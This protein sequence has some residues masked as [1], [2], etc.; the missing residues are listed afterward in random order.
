MIPYGK[1]S[2]DESDI[3][4]V[5]EV[6]RSDFLTCGPK[7]DEFEE[8]FA[9]M[10]GAKYAVSCANGTAALHLAMLAAKIGA[11]DRV[12]TTPI[13]FLASANCAVY[14]GAK[15][16]FADVDPVSSCLCP[17]SLAERWR[18]GTKAVVAVDFAGQPADMQAI[19]TVARERG[20]LVIEDACHAVGGKF[21]YQGVEHTVGGHEW[22]DMTVF[23]FHP[24][25]TLTTGEGGMVVTNNSELAERLRLLRCHGMVKDQQ[26][27]VS[28]GQS[29]TAIAEEQVGQLYEMQ[30]PGFNYRLS[31]IHAALGISQL[32]RLSS[33][34]TRRQEIVNQYNDAFSSLEGVEI[35]RL[36]SWLENE[37][38]DCHRLSWHLYVLRFDWA[39][40]GISR[41]ELIKRL[42]AAGVGTQV[43]YL[44]VYLQP[45]YATYFPSNGL[46]NADAVSKAA[47]SLPLYPS[48]T[49]ADVDKV[50][51]ILIDELVATGSV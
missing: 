39:G 42:R 29:G 3:A 13:T 41:P 33:F 37:G 2:I 23:S 47:L 12:V 34:V 43:H 35:P 26:D 44:P 24:V 14:V 40:L 48:M 31:D 6:L 22:A 16:D 7:V 32:K 49:D 45:W 17:E 51:S 28:F 11:G 46:D 50:I 19:S 18:D 4:A 38:S 5:V 30:E 10:C 8:G 36:G 21:R 15:V 27:F 9:R 20:A 25:K 1:Q